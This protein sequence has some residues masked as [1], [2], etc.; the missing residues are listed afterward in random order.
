[1][2][3]SDKC[4][5]IIAKMLEK[6][7]SNPVIDIPNLRTSEDSAPKFTKYYILNPIIDEM[8]AKNIPINPDHLDDGKSIG[9]FGELLMKDGQVFIEADMQKVQKMYP[10][11]RFMNAVRKSN[12]EKA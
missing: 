8:K 12:T 1:M 3:I 7:A 4:E 11:I 10:V 6:M 2:R 9:L 5:M